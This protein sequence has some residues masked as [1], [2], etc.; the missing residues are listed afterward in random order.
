MD[1]S[2]SEIPLGSDC[3]IVDRLRYLDNL[4]TGVSLERSRVPWRETLNEVLHSGLVEG[5]LNTT[6]QNH[7]LAIASGAEW[8]GVVPSLAAGDAAVMGRKAGDAMLRLR[9]LTREEDRTII[10][11]VESLLDP[12]MF[13]LHME[14]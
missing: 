3:L 11:Y 4:G 14:F 2:G 1:I 6:L 10:E 5:S 9:R 7:G 12:D 13:G 8:A